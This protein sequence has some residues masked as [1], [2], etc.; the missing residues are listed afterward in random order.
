MLGAGDLVAIVVAVHWVGATAL[1]DI[2]G[3]SGSFAY[4]VVG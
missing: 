4:V 3:T 2:S 1:G